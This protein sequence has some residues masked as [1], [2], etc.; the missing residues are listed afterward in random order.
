MI[1]N[2]YQKVYGKENFQQDAN[3]TLNGKQ[4]DHCARLDDLLDQELFDPSFIPNPMSQFFGPFNSQ[5][6]QDTSAET[7]QDFSAD[8]Y[9]MP[10]FPP[11]YDISRVLLTDYSGE[12]Q[13]QQASPLFNYKTELCKKWVE[14]KGQYCPYNDKCRF[15]HGL[16]EV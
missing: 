12:R 16:E 10:F 1:K 6:Y 7:H 15:A 8:P 5:D 14:S 11:S 3:L 13:D 9:A 4:K 2:F